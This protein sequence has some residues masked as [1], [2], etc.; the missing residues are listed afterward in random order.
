MRND[1]KLCQE[2]S[3]KN[4]MH[5]DSSVSGLPLLNAK[6]H[7]PVQKAHQAERQTPPT[8]RCGQGE[9]APLVNSSWCSSGFKETLMP[10]L[11]SENTSA[12]KG[13][14]GAWVRWTFPCTLQV[15]CKCRGVWRNARPDMYRN[16]SNCTKQAL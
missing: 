7:D 3:L 13:N 6:I 8:H 9:W 4:L 12:V 16:F 5:G 1:V 10:S 11:D 15:R 2:S 14:G